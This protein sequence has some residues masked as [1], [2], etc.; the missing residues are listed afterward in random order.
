MFGYFDR[1]GL[2][3][4]RQ[5][6]GFGD[7]HVDLLQ[8]LALHALHVRRQGGQPLGPQ[9]CKI[10]RSFREEVVMVPSV[11]GIDRHDQAVCPLGRCEIAQDRLEWKGVLFIDRSGHPAGPVGPGKRKD[12]AE[13]LA[14]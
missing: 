8:R 5:R 6:Q 9:A 10:L 1:L 14:V 2:I 3:V 11:I 7:I 13:F 4:A 12:V